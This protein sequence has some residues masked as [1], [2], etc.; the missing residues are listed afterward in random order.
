M[1]VETDDVRSTKLQQAQW[2]YL[3]SAR[4]HSRWIS[5]FHIELTKPIYALEDFPAFVSRT[6]LPFS[7]IGLGKLT[8]SLQPVWNRAL[9]I[10]IGSVIDKYKICT[11]LS[12]Y[13]TRDETQRRL[14]NSQSTFTEPG[15][16]SQWWIRFGNCGQHKDQKENNAERNFK[17]TCPKNIGISPIRKFYFKCPN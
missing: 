5:V 10:M 8:K 7:L 13:S 15:C 2:N 9:L 1:S 3:G 11:P 14:G 4:F 6:M 16:C 17:G 12:L